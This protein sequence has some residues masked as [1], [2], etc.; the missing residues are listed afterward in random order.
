M[1]KGA[2][3]GELN[4]DDR[5]RL[6]SMLRSFGDLG[7]GYAYRGSERAGVSRFP[8]AG[9]VTEEPREPQIGRAHV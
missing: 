3:D 9:D 5:E 6:L 4:K 8:G 1:N 7:E 2:L